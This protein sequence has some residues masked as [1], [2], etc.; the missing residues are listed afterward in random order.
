MTNWVQGRGLGLIVAAA[1]MLTGCI[2]GGSYDPAD[3]RP[4]YRIR[5]APFPVPLPKAKPSVEKAQARARR[6][7]RGKLVARSGDTLFSLARRVG[8]PLEDLIDT[9]GLTAPYTLYVGQRLTLSN[10]A[11]HTVRRGETAYSISKQYGLK[12]GALMTQNGIRAPYTLAIGQ[13]LQ[14]PDSR[15]VARATGRPIPS[16]STPARRAPAR[17]APPP[18]RTSSR[19][20][21]PLKGTVLSRFGRRADGVQN[22]GINIA[23]KR[24]AA[25]KA[26]EDGVVAYASDALQGYGN[27]VLVKH[28]G[29]WITAYAHLSAISVAEGQRVT[30]GQIIGK[31][32]QSGGVDR[33]QVHFETRRARR[34]VNPLT[35]LEA[36]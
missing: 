36:R 28:G 7:A 18:P 35:V 30:R 29:G 19:F 32:G 3:I 10:P 13:K 26:A 4:A 11:I 14:L 23:A 34:A 12:V 27:L 9:N 31:A 22:D 20:A 15:S 16:A 6:A 17:S 33:P 1:I 24:G 2:G 5:N 8:L 25:V 21:W